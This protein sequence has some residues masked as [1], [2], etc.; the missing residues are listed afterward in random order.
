MAWKLLHRRKLILIYVDAS[1]EAHSFEVLKLWRHTP[2][3]WT[4]H[5]DINLCPTAAELIKTIMD[6]EEQL[7]ASS[8]SNIA[9]LVWA[10][11]QKQG[12][13]SHNVHRHVDSHVVDALDGETEMEGLVADSKPATSRKPFK[14]AGQYKFPLANNCSNWI[15]PCPCR[16]CSSPLHYDCECASRK[17]QNRPEV[18]NLPMS[19]AN[20]AYHKSYIAMLEDDD[21]DF[22]KHCAT[23]QALLDT[24]Q[25][26][27]MLVVEY[28]SNEASALDASC[29]A[30]TP[31]LLA[32]E[33]APFE[34]SEET[35]WV[36]L[37][38]NA[39]K[40]EDRVERL[41]EDVYEPIRAWERPAGHVVRGVNAFKLHCH[42]N[43]LREPAAIVIG[44][45]GAAPMLI[46]LSFPG[47]LMCTWPKAGKLLGHLRRAQDTLKAHKQ[48]MPQEQDEFTKW[49]ACLAT[50]VLNLDAWTRPP[51]SD[52]AHG[53]ED[54]PQNPESLG[55][56]SKTADPGPDQV[57]PSD[58]LKE[59]IDIDPALKPVQ[60]EALFEVIW[61]NQAA[62]GFNG[63]LGHLQSKVHIELVPGTKCKVDY[64]HSFICICFLYFSFYSSQQ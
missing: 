29:E 56:G 36:A 59:V 60:W 54:Q 53:R 58:Q 32:D 17:Q 30:A 26:A 23:F 1:D 62:F 38:V 37:P 11:L 3:T 44:D 6:K 15:P 18:K 4:A 31:V 41:A 9:R 47:K 48:M 5:V 33:W 20:D 39:V 19:K 24:D 46:S 8:I 50:L 2:T 52:L 45:S 25:I 13:S 10:E 34:S 12:N 27:E 42:V 28:V 43:S 49:T 55:W 63:W 57:Y 61:C 22:N 51:P 14:A 16:H 35:A 40:S 21:D 7:L 64:I